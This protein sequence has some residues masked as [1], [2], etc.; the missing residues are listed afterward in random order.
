VL[1]ANGRYGE[2]NVTLQPALDFFQAVRAK[3]F[4]RQAEALSVE[5]A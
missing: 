2:A 4:I 3:R 5:S 1:A